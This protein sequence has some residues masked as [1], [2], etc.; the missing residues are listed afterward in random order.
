MPGRLD[1]VIPCTMIPSRRGDINS[2]QKA[3]R[4]MFIRTVSPYSSKHFHFPATVTI[5]RAMNLILKRAINFHSGASLP[6]IW[7]RYHRTTQCMYACMHEPEH[8]T[9]NDYRTFY[10]FIFCLCEDSGVIITANRWRVH[11][12][13]R[14][15]HT[16]DVRLQTDVT[17]WCH[18]WCR[19]DG[20]PP[21]GCRW[22]R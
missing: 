15:R 21:S 5:C 12:Q 19:H 13:I 8:S 10:V 16:T 9:V 2:P 4:S 22:C 14:P 17:D 20:S 6:T 3:G 11:H 1:T 18:W 7:E